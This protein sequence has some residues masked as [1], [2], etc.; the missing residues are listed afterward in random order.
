MEG[1]IYFLNKETKHVEP[2]SFRERPH[3]LKVYNSPARRKMVKSGRQCEKSTTISN[4]MLAK[5]VANPGFGALYTNPSQEQTRAFNYQK[6]MPSLRMSPMLQAWFPDYLVGN[7]STKQAVNEGSL[8]LQHFKFNPD[9]VRGFSV[10]LLVFDELQD[11]ISIHLP[12]VEECASHST[13]QEY[14]YCGTPKS[15]D[16]PIEEYWS[17]QSIQYEWM[18]P[19]RG[20]GH[21]NLMDESNIGKTHLICSRCGKRIHPADPKAQWVYVARPNVAD[22]IEGFHISQLMIPTTYASSI[23]WDRLLTKQ[24]TYDRQR[25]MNEVMG[26][27]HDSGLRP[28]TREDLL[29][30]TDSRIRA[31]EEYAELVLKELSPHQIY[32]GIDWGGGSQTSFTYLVLAT[33]MEDRFT[34][35]Y[36]HKFEGPEADP[37]IQLEILRQMLRGFKVA[38][39]GADFGQGKFTNSVLDKAFPG[40]VVQYQYVPTMKELIKLNPVE[41]PMMYLVKKHTVLAKV[42]N[43]IKKGGVFR[44]PGWDTFERAGMEFLNIYSEFNEERNETIYRVAP[45]TSD[46]AFHAFLFAYLVSMLDYPNAAVLYS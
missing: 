18:V 34:P 36:F 37:A 7:V 15:F 9:R 46:D 13:F 5:V 39:I 42:F 41:R 24:K 20:C 33:Y 23:G 45:G 26:L 40:K 29:K 16:N 17:R 6:I 21:W 31:T 12:V 10:D 3:L 44:F 8:F 32:A 19:C 35:F 4:I 2:F 14:V 28:L 1:T 43:A 27:S 11:M 30:N 25:F 38:R 22:P